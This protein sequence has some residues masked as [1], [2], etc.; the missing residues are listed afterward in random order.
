[1]GLPAGEISEGQ[2]RRRSGWLLTHLRRP[3]IAIA[4]VAAGAAG[5]AGAAR[6]TAGGAS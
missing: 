4:A 1:V 5:A 2:L 3:A 6:A